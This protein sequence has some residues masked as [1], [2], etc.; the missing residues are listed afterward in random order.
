MFLHIDAVIMLSVLGYGFPLMISS[1]GGSVASAMAANVSMIRLTQSIW[2]L[3]S[4]ES[5]RNM[6]PIKAMKIATKFA[7]S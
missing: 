2:T 4:G 7:V 6:P 5:P 1:L 3:L